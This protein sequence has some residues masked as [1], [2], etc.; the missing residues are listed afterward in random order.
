MNGLDLFL[1]Q[2]PD[3][4][5]KSV[6]KYYNYYRPILENETINYIFVQQEF[7]PDAL[8]FT[9]K[10]LLIC[11][12]KNL[13]TTIEIQLDIPL[14]EVVYYGVIEGVIT[15][16]FVIKIGKTNIQHIIYNF[17]KKTSLYIC[18]QFE[19]ITKIN[20]A[21]WEKLMKEYEY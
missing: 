13:G 8:I 4:L 16:D 15:D 12:Q 5:H 19:R 6:F 14:I 9:N 21:I 2:N 20:Q 7:Y 10:R 3:D 17:P 18:N 1:S 11:I